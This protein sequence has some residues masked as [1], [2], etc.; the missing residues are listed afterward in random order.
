[1]IDQAPR[2]S[3]QLSR[4]LTDQIAFLFFRPFKPNLKDMWRAYLA[5]GLFTTWLVGI[6]R[7]WDHP[8]A[9]VWQYAGLGSV[10][11]VFAL[12]VLLW[13]ILLPFKRENL[14]YLNILI[15]I[16]LTSLPAV[17]YAIPVERFLSLQSAQTVNV[18]FLM[19]VAAWRVA[20]YVT[21]LRRVG[22]F[23]PVTVGVLT[24]LPL[25]LIVTTLTGLNLEHAVFQTM[26]GIRDATPNDSAYGVMVVVSLLS[27]LSTP[28]LLIWYG[29]L[30][31]ATM[32]NRGVE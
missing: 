27:V 22:R 17:F 32:K 3:A 7:Y 21:F 20:L 25:A 29:F 8:K 15:F 12:A 14:S 13:L 10:V 2:L 9:H 23:S 31:Y 28:I 1:M 11:Y 4:V 5:W 26:G 24:L 6:G 30:V 18:W 19:I 16:T